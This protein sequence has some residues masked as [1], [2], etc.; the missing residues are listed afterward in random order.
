MESSIGIPSYKYG[1]EFNKD[2]LAMYNDYSTN[3][4]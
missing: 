3:Q 4:N 1:T 2:G